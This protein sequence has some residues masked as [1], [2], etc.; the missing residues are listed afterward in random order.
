MPKGLVTLESIFNTDDQLKKDKSSLQIKEEHYEEVEIATGKK[1]KLGKVCTP[2]ERQT[3]MNLCNEFQD[4]IAWSYSDLKGFDPN[5]AQHTIELEPGAKP[6][7][8]K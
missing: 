4:I 6:V 7:R 5:I 2:E 8:Q 1:L 3:F